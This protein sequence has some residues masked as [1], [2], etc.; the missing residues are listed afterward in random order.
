M[1]FP[2]NQIPQSMLSTIGLAAGALYPLPNG[3]G[4][5]FQTTQMETDNYN[6]G[7][8]RYDHYFGNNDQLF[9]RYAAS[10]ANTL[11]PLPIN[12][13]NV[14]GFPVTDA[15]TT[16]SFTISDVHLI[17]PSTVQTV[18]LAFFRNAFI[19]EDAQNHTPG[20]SLGFTYQPTLAANSGIPYLIEARTR[21]P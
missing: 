17:S 14:P 19:Y 16:N 18:R 20:S 12:G 8:F 21:S 5:L 9:A 6:Q 10:A 4:N 7:G 15:I 1:P 13:S 11:D 2:N 3:G